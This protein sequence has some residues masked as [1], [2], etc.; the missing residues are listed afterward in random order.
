MLTNVQTA[1]QETTVPIFTT[2]PGSTTVPP[3]TTIPGTT[4]PATTV[5]PGTQSILDLYPGAAAAWS[6]RKL[7]S[8]Q[9]LCLR[10]KREGDGVESK[11]LDL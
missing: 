8:A 3:A 7:R 6:A 2:I 9:T 10:G 4:V 11:I 1:G 5:P